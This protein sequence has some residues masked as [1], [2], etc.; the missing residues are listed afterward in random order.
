MESSESSVYDIRDK[1]ELGTC[2]SHEQF[3]ECGRENHI[4]DGL[5][6]ISRLAGSSLSDHP[7]SLVN[8]NVECCRSRDHCICRVKNYSATRIP[9]LGIMNHHLHQTESCVGESCCRPIPQRQP[10]GQVELVV[11]AVNNLSYFSNRSIPTCN[12]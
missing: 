9:S 10:T 3:E 7:S 12:L 2:L 6:M 5:D 1:I 8:A 11:D 4:G